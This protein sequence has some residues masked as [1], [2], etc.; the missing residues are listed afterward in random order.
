MT[1]STLV[2][3]LCWQAAGPPPALRHARH[4]AASMAMVD[5]FPDPPSVAGTVIRAKDSKFPSVLEQPADAARSV[6]VSAPNWLQPG[7]IQFDPFDVLLAPLDVPDIGAALF[8]R[9]RV[10][11][12]PSCWRPSSLVR[13]PGPDSPGSWLRSARV[14]SRSAAQ[15]PL[16]SS[17]QASWPQSPNRRPPTPPPPSPPLPPCSYAWHC[18]SAPPSIGLTPLSITPGGHRSAARARLP[19]RTSG[20]HLRQGRASAGQDTRGGDR[21]S[22][23]PDCAVAPRQE[24]EPSGERT[25]RHP[26]TRIR[27]LRRPRRAGGP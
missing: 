25:S 3:A 10:N 24:R 13:W 21:R 17:A 14:T 8:V 16:G 9:Q 27:H 20:H 4:H 22:G 5:L 19:T 7:T 6:P 1:V 2:A 23:H 26:R 15:G 12:A 11:T 18:S